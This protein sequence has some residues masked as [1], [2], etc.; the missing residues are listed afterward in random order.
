MSFPC[1]GC[2]A[3]IAG[4]PDRLLLR[5]GACGARLRSRAVETSASSPLF[6]VQVTG[7]PETL[8]RVEI[9]WDEAERRRLSSWL[10]VASVVTVALVLV[11]FVLAR[12]L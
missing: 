4:R 1:P 6:E 5:C 3:P 12:M 8:R 2:D 7:R 9:P 11:L 10:L